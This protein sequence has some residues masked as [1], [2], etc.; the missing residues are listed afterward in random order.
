MKSQEK[1]EA[2]RGRE[3]SSPD[4]MP[5]DV[6]GGAL[7]EADL[8][9]VDTAAKL[10]SIPISTIS[11]MIDLTLADVL[12]EYALTVAAVLLTMVDFHCVNFFF[13]HA[14]MAKVPYICTAAAPQPYHWNGGRAPPFSLFSYLHDLL[15]VNIRYAQPWPKSLAPSPEVLA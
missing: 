10:Q 11:R 9:L 15:C 8:D 12:I 3:S 7:S 1:Q 2:L 13:R 5:R 4:D 6:C 14:Q